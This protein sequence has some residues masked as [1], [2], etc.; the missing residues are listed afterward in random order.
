MNRSK[1]AAA[2]GAA[3]DPTTAVP[4]DAATGVQ[5]P[6]AAAVPVAATSP[7]TASSSVAGLHLQMKQN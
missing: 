1:V 3:A 5:D 4:N 6:A 2:A 7:S